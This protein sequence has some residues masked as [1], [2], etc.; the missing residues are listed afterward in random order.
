MASSRKKTAG[1]KSSKKTFAEKKPKKGLEIGDTGT[2]ILQGIVDEEYNKKLSDIRGIAVF[3][4]MR[5]S[6]GT[7]RAAMLA[8]TLPIRQARWYVEPA[9][10]D[11]ADVEIAQFVESA[12]KEWQTISWDDFIRQAL[13]MLPFGVMAFEKVFEMK[14]V[15]GVDRIVWKK[16]AP[17]M[18]KSIYAWE[19]TTGEAGIQQRTVKGDIVNIPMDKLLI[20]V[21]EKEGDN[22]WGTSMLRAGYKHWHI[23]NTFYK[24]DSIAFERQG[25][26]IP[27]AKLPEGFTES[28]RAKAETILKNVRANHQAHIIVPHDYEIG[29]LDMMGKAT[30]DPKESIAHH[31]REIVKSMLAQFLELGSTDSGSRALS[32]D[33][34]ELFLLSLQAVANS[35]S[36]VINT[37]AVKQLVDLNFEGIMKYPKLCSTGISRQDAKALADTYKVLIDSTGVKAGENDEQYFRELLGLPE[38]DN[39][40]DPNPEPAD[41]QGGDDD[42]IDEIGMSEFG[43]SIKKKVYPERSSVADAVATSLSKFSANGAIAEIKRRLSILPHDCAHHSDESDHAPFF[44]MVK[45]ELNRMLVKLRKEVFAEGNSFKSYRDLTFAEKKVD[46]NALQAKMDALEETFDKATK[47]LL[48]AERAKFMAT[49]TKAVQS[50]DKEAIKNATFKIEAVYASV[51]KEKMKEA[52][53]YG[54]TNAA[55][56]LGVA[57]PAN[58]RDALAQIDIQAQAIAEAHI[59]ELTTG[60]KMKVAEAIAKGESTIAALAIADAAMSEAIEQLVR[61]TSGIVLSMQINNGRGTVYASNQPKIYALQRSEILDFRTCNYC[62]SV[63]GRVVQKTDPFAKNSIFHSGCRGIWVAILMDESELPKIDG[64]PQSIKDRFGDTVNDLIQPKNPIT[65]KDSLAR[66]EAEKRARRKA[67]KENKK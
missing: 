10:E 44:S 20:F 35:L 15:D 46:F 9:S 29:F 25:L 64:I 3:D 53:E 4:E 7:V 22:W 60:A 37:H 36:G 56:E 19:M 54:K 28:E 21:N 27:Y 34:S 17:R 48:Q 26:G 5:R 38:R 65:K 43:D 39:S 49:L 18:P 6:D 47:D 30:R 16:F 24:I 58:A 51:I 8:C 40:N 11:T 2:Q 63:D 55:K 12:L 13:L 66:E 67:D 32:Q 14:S 31:N 41:G 45:S 23:K 1:E 33:Q 61:D 57:S 50:G 62:L 59:A 42:L 52:Y